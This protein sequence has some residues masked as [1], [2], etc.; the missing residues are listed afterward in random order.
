MSRAVAVL[1]GTA[2]PSSPGI[3]GRPAAASCVSP[4]DRCA[5]DS[6]SLGGLASSAAPP[7]SR[8]FPHRT[9]AAFLAISLSFLSGIRL[10]ASTA[11]A[12]AIVAISRRRSGE[13]DSALI[14]ARAAAGLSDFCGTKLNYTLRKVAYLFLTCSFCARYAFIVDSREALQRQE[15]NSPRDRTAGAGSVFAEGLGRLVRDLG[16]PLSC[17]RRRRL[18]LSDRRSRG[19]SAT[20]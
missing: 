8:F 19:S 2:L 13:S 18:L 4:S 16:A 17:G 15:K 5:E 1:S 12:L 3:G 9:A 7:R 10:R 11:A 14:R 20:W 6:V